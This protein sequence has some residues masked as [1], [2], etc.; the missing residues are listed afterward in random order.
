MTVI[1]HNAISPIE[2]EKSCGRRDDN[3]YDDG[4]DKNNNDITKYV[5]IR[6]SNLKCKKKMWHLKNT[7]IIRILKALGNDKKL[8]TNI[9]KYPWPHLFKNDF[10]KLKY[11]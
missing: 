7:V 3:D 8:P 5:N 4:D 2:N 1:T 11:V 9:L 10:K 6:L